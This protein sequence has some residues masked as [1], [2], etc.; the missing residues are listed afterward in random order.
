MDRVVGGG[1][2]GQA[3]SIQDIKLDKGYWTHLD[4]DMY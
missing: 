1:S 3:F 2:W 4:P